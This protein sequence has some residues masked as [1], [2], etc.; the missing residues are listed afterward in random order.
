MPQ[1]HSGREIP[2]SRQL[3][4][5]E[6]DRGGVARLMEALSGNAKAVAVERHHIDKDY[7]DTFS[8]ST[9]ISTASLN[10]MPSG[11]RVDTV[12]CNPSTTEATPWLSG[13][14]NTHALALWG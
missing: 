9:S 12:E 3:V 11:I 6:L 13:S 4:Q 5:P 2:P 1:R 10:G 8:N 7:R 14:T